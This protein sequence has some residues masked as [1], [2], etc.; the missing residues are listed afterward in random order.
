MSFIFATTGGILHGG[1]GLKL[2]ERVGELRFILGY[3]L[4]QSS[5]EK[6]FIVSKPYN[7]FC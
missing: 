1:V 6:P 7:L 2:V 5:I 3:L 4:A